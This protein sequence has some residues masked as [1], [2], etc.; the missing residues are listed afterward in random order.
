MGYLLVAFF[1][2]VQAVFSEMSDSVFKVGTV[3]S[4]LGVSVFVKEVLVRVLEI[5]PPLGGHISPFPIRVSRVV[6]RWSLV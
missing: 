4:D 3:H 2:V 6:D 5:R 1:C